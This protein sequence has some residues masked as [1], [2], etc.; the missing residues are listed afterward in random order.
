[1]GK[2]ARMQAR[3]RL[4]EQRRREAERARR[5]KVAGVVG[6]AVA[7]IV[8]VVLIGVV[9]QTQ[10]S[11]VSGVVRPTNVTAEGGIAFGPASGVPVLTVYED[12]QCPACKKFEEA[13]GT[14]IDRLVAE[15]KVRVVYTP[16][17]IIGAE[18][19][20]AG[21]A[22]MC[23]A[24]LGPD[25]FKAFSK[26]LFAH[27]PPENSGQLTA[28]RLTELGKQAGI[29]DSGWERCVKD[30]KYLP[31]MKDITEKASRAGLR[32]TP[33]VLLN[34]KE[35]PEQG[36]SPEGLPVVVEQAAAGAG[37][38]SAAPSATPSAAPAEATASASP[39]P[40]GGGDR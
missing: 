8:V 6:A 15:G 26:T 28:R 37:T 39:S 19:E 14:T 35:L 25:R 20:A 9:V 4:K 17:A 21:S 10:R 34:G 24:D 1:M 29:S 5:A 7:V 12:Y 13:M 27:Q 30:G 11:E 3:E 2:A 32:G 22:A 36:Y 38:S 16:V 31:W 18:S 23:A 40:A 33:W